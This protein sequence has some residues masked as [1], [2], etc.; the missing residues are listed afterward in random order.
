MISSMKWYITHDIFSILRGFQ[1]AIS[2][3]Y[4]RFSKG[5]PILAWAL[6]AVSVTLLWKKRPRN[7][8]FTGCAFY[9]VVVIVPLTFIIFLS[10]SIRSNTL[11]MHYI[12]VLCMNTRL[13]NRK[14]SSGGPLQLARF[15]Q[16]S[17]ASS[18]NLHFLLSSYS[19]NFAKVSYTKVMD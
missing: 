17:F 2:V 7:F 3:I 8:F 5:E 1:I 4:T 15:L 19:S 10:F 14:K 12:C 13:H 18:S 16:Q 11:H 6:S 9:I